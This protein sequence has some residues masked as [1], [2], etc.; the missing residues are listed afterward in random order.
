MGNFIKFLKSGFYFLP[1]F[2]GI[3]GMGAKF[4]ERLFLTVTFVEECRG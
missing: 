2:V 1:S 4:R 3:G